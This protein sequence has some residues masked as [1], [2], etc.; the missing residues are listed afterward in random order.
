M[1]EEYIKEIGA[2]YP[3]AECNLDVLYVLI[4]LLI[5][6]F[7][8]FI[9]AYPDGYM[10]SYFSVLKNLSNY[11]IIYALRP[12]NSSISLCRSPLVSLCALV[13]YTGYLDLC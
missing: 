1:N 12:S 3:I 4:Y 5:P 7:A 9:V 13:L 10:S 8:S 11:Y 6:S 2:L